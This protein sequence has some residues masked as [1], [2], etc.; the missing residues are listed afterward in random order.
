MADLARTQKPIP[1]RRR[2]T[3]NRDFTLPSR[4][5][6]DTPRLEVNAPLAG[7]NQSEARELAAILGL[8]E[9]AVSPAVGFLEQREAQQRDAARTAGSLASAAGVAD[10]EQLANSRA[11]AQGYY[12]TGAQRT[13][14]ELSKQ[15]EA[16]VNERLFNEDDPATLEDINDVLN[17]LFA[18]R[19]LNEDGTPR[20]FGD[21]LAARVMAEGLARIRS[22]V[23]PK[24][25]EYIRTKQNEQLAGNQAFVLVNGGMPEI[26]SG[27][28][29]TPLGTPAVAASLEAR[30]DAA[31]GP[32]QRTPAAS[33]GRLVAPFAGFGAAPTSRIGAARAGG[34][35]HN[36]EDFAVP[37]GT[38]V[39]APMAGTV[40]RVY[41]N[42]AGG[43]Q[44]LVRLDNGAVVGFAHLSDTSG[45]AAGQRVEGGQQ[46]A[47]SG[48]TG[49]SSGPHVHMTVTVDGKKVSPSEYFATADAAA[50]VEPG[51]NE[52]PNLRDRLAQPEAAVAPPVVNFEAVMA[53]RPP[54]I[55][56]GEWKAYMVPAIIENAEIAGKPEI[57]EGLWRST[58][59]DGTPSFN[60][61]EISD[62]RDAAERIREER[63]IETRRLRNERH[64]KNGDLIIGEI[65]NGRDPSD[66]TL[67]DLANKDELDPRFAY[68]IIEQRENEREAALREASADARAARAEAEREY[69]LEAATL[70]MEREAGI[71]SDAT[72]EDD[73]RRLE[74]GEFGEGKAA[75][76]RFRQ[77][78]ASTT[79]SVQRLQESPLGQHYATL[80][81]E[82][83]PKV[84]QGDGSMLSRAQGPRSN[85]N[86]AAALAHYNSLI[87]EGKSPRDAYAQTVKTYGGGGNDAALR[88]RLEE[89][90]GR[91]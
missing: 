19:A 89:L 63:R 42:A 81:E 1:A 90:R 46:I 82:A 84:S 30:F 28:Q 17:G 67:I 75:L 10:E 86:R 56:P 11:Y 70:Q 64:E 38:P 29:E 62:I 58:R 77:I 57:L 72:H 23:L 51:G 31:F 65:L 15:A 54:S 71:L 40:E 9:D 78:R 18:S 45:L 3:T 5:E 32:E 27:S 66:D 73:I 24:A 47:L 85:A 13:V 6:T 88:S 83:F 34:R 49:R 59:P 12:T 25:A 79:A 61:K 48:N 36:G 35:S 21:P 7:R 74:R 53:R 80:L 41:A 44:V 55:S 87:A 60:P 43:K 39:V 69:D 37:I 50:F 76:R 8:A 26:F 52:D 4:R 20:N 68:S 22:E 91:Q 14:I 2:G 16:L 33:A